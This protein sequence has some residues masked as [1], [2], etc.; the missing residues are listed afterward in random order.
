[1]SRGA[2]DSRGQA[3]ETSQETTITIQVR[4]NCNLGNDGISDKCDHL[5]DM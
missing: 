5:Q 3:I 2:Q 1:M 4:D